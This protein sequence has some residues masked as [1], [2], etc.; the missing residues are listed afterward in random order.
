MSEPTYGSGP[1]YDPQQG[2]GGAPGWPQQA[3]Q[4]GGQQGPQGPQYGTGQQPQQPAPQPHPQPPYG[5]Y[6]Q[7]QPGP[8]GYPSGGYQAAPSGRSPAAPRTPTDRLAL[9]ATVVT[10]VGYVCAG[11]GVLGFILW[12]TVDGDGTY[13]F[14]TAL[15]T[16][17]V[18]IGLGGLNYAVGSWLAS[19]GD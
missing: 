7:Q 8:A 19:R 12:L 1:A 16:L 6:S 9:S 18:G 15:Q 11:A 17:V 2:Y 3:K 13:R 5:S 14:A 10:I 4:Y